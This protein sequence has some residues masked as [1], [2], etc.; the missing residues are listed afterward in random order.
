MT[1]ARKLQQRPVRYERGEIT[2]RPNEPAMQ[3]ECKR[4][5]SLLPQQYHLYERAMVD[6][7]LTGVRHVWTVLPCTSCPLDLGRKS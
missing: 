7:T 5:G 6:P 2:V 3:Q 1:A 4:C